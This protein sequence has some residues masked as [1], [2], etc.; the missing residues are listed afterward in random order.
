MTT[1]PLGVRVSTTVTSLAGTGGGVVPL[2]SRG[3]SVFA[4]SL[5]HLLSASSAPEAEVVVD[6]LAKNGNGFCL[7][8][9]SNSTQ[10]LSS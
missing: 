7:V 8:T 10:I 3:P 9:L 5:L 6:E 2:A 4:S 1:P